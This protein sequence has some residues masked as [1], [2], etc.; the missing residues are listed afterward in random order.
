M[1]P[2]LEQKGAGAE[3]ELSRELQK[4]HAFCSQGAEFSP[5]VHLVDDNINIDNYMTYTDMN[6]SQNPLGRINLDPPLCLHL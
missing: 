6:M 1:R 3:E 4:K 5:T 2:S